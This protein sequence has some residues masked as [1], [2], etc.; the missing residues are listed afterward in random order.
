MLYKTNGIQLFAE[1]DGQWHLVR[2]QEKKVQLTG[3]TYVDGWLYY[4]TN[5]C[6]IIARLAL[7][8][9]A[10][11]EEERMGRVER[12]IQESLDEWDDV[13]TKVQPYVTMYEEV[14]GVRQ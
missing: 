5:E 10:I 7:D 6:D 9:E 11:E 13:P 12:L 1:L 3:T 8:L 4:Q 2:N 14:Y